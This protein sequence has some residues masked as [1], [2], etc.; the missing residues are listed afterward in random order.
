LID[1]ARDAHAGAG[2]ERA[3]RL[4]QEVFA[5]GAGSGHPTHARVLHGAGQAAALAGKIAAAAVAGERRRVHR[6]GGLVRQLHHHLLG[7]RCSAGA[8]GAGAPSLP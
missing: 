3:P 5:P 4:R 8:A 7:A 1:A 2:A 6:A